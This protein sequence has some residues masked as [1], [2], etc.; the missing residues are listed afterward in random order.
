MRRAPHE[1]PA[2]RFRLRQHPAARTARRAAGCRRLRT[3]SR[4]GYRR[5]ARRASGHPLRGRRPRR[6]GASAACRAC[7]TVRPNWP[8]TGGHALLLLRAAR[9]SWSMP[10]SHVSTSQNIIAV[11]RA[12]SRPD[13][14]VED[15]LA[16]LTPVGWLVEP[17][18]REIL[19]HGTRRRRRP[20]R[21]AGCPTGIRP[22]CYGRRSAST[23]APMISPR[24]NGPSSAT[25]PRA[26]PPGSSFGGAEVRPCCAS[27]SER[28]TSTTSSSRC[29]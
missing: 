8:L 11:L 29:A 20:A 9:G 19:R 4:P 21:A 7:T 12:R 3:P 6:S 5:P 1:G 18:A 2:G 27:D 16:A 22:V 28:P 17:L 24:S 25:T 26:S 13:T 23:N 14:S 10:C 15:A